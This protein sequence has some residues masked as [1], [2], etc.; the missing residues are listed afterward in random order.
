MKFIPVSEVEKSKSIEVGSP[1][2]LKCEL[3]DVNAQVLW[4]KDGTKLSPNSELDF[5]GD[6][7]LRQ[8]TVQT[9]K[10]SDT[11]HYTCHVPGETISFKVHVQGDFYNSTT[12]QTK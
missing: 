11:G 4:C 5:H 3:S 10:L 1:I 8:L 2:V 7:N 9:A 6:G 12:N